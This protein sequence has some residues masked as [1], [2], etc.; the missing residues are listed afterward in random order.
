MEQW[1]HGP[2]F[3][4]AVLRGGAATDRLGTP[5]VF[6]DYDAKYIANDTQYRIPCGW[7]ASRNRN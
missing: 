7:T 6:Y 4:V 5:H 2:E 3:T 1:I